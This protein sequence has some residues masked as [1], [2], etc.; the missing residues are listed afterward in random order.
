MY[1]ALVNVDMS[2]TGAYK[3]RP[4]LVD[5]AALGNVAT[6]AFGDQRLAVFTGHGCAG[7]VAPLTE[8]LTTA[9]YSRGYV[10]SA[11]G[12]PVPSYDP[13]FSTSVDTERMEFAPAV[14]SDG[15]TPVLVGVTVVSGIG[16]AV[17]VDPATREI[18]AAG[19][20]LSGTPL[21]AAHLAMAK[22]GNHVYVTYVDNAGNYRIDQIDPDTGAVTSRR[23]TAGTGLQF[24]DA[25]GA[26]DPNDYLMV[27]VTTSTPVAFVATY[28]VASD[29]A[30]TLLRSHSAPARQDYIAICTRI[31]G[32]TT[33]EWA[34]V[35]QNTAGTAYQVSR[36]PYIGPGTVTT[37]TVLS[38]RTATSATRG[39]GISHHPDS[40]TFLYALPHNRT[41][42]G[43]GSTHY[44]SLV[45]TNGTGGS[46]A[47]VGGIAG[48]ELHDATLV[49]KIVPETRLSGDVSWTLTVL[50]ELDELQPIALT[51]AV[52]ADNVQILS[53]HAVGLVVAPPGPAY[54]GS[55]GDADYWGALGRSRLTY[56]GV[57]VDSVDVGALITLDHDLVKL[58][59]AASSNGVSLVAG[60]VP[61][62]VAAGTTAPAPLLHRP[63]IG[64]AVGAVAG[65]GKTLTGTYVVS[66]VWE[67][68]DYAG[69]VWTS[70]AAAPVS[71]TLAGSENAIQLSV[72]RPPASVGLAGNLTL[73][74]YCSTDGG[75]VLYRD[76]ATTQSTWYSSTTTLQMVTAVDLDV[77]IATHAVLYT[78][79]S[80]LP[81][82]GTPPLKTVVS[83]RT[84]LAGIHAETGDI[85]FSLPRTDGAGIHWSEVLRVENPTPNDH[86]TALVSTDAAV[87]VFWRDRIGWIV[88]EG[89]NQQGQGPGWALQMIPDATAGCA[90][91]QCVTTCPEGILFV[92]TE[93]GPHMLP[94]GGG[95][96]NPIGYPLDWHSLARPTIAGVTHIGDRY[97]VRIVLAAPKS[98]QL[99]VTPTSGWGGPGMAV[100]W[101]TYHYARGGVWSYGEMGGL[102]LPVNHASSDGARFVRGQ[103]I[104]HPY[105]PTRTD[106]GGYV[107]MLLLTG[108]TALDQIARKQGLH[109]LWRLEILADVETSGNVVDLEC[110]VCYDGDSSDYSDHDHTTFDGDSLYVRVGKQL[111]ET[112]KIA[113]ADTASSS[114][115]SGVVLRAIDAHV[116]TYPSAKSRRKP[117]NKRN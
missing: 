107:R 13:V 79:T 108:W 29:G 94:F 11:F 77:D 56:D 41:L 92:D 74:A 73:V 21:G 50:R 42:T 102:A 70:E 38:P 78:E 106:T 86:P 116:G 67:F 63:T 48:A 85:W 24:I 25:V 95:A 68:A 110:R 19:V 15:F 62:P 3:K 99:S 5:Q 23:V 117:G 97:E 104:D 58:G 14:R 111:L 17:L 31:T 33:R 82:S 20:P 36:A 9:T 26:T 113:I 100:V 84:R 54:V 8:E 105:D 76:S 90:G 39:I 34:V 69:N 81:H 57:R 59:H 43:V 7:G 28:S 88:G 80:E 60:G 64:A 46:A 61:T 72:T 87:V 35:H 12:L 51:L 66:A 83:H 109:R 52:S 96:P 27:A 75:S 114:G 93:R 30:L 16:V 103:A 40:D 89:L 45:T 4:G 98:V 32:P 71:V 49:R 47:V 112:Y 44:L 22:V 101:L 10:S 6:H 115:T 2:D 55:A 53:Q 1:E 91:Q 18:A 65:G 37:T